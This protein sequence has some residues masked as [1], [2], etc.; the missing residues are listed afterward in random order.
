MWDVIDKETGMELFWSSD[1][2]AALL[3]QKVNKALD[4]LLIF[5]EE[6]MRY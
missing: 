3:F 4:T 2:A 1:L 6:D 5:V